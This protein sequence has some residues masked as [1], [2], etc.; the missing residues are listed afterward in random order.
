SDLYCLFEVDSPEA[1]FR[2]K[3]VCYD[4][5]TLVVRL[6][7]KKVIARLPDGTLTMQNL[8]RGI[9]YSLSRM[10]E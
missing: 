4:R 3:T 6:G 10:E 7:R 1:S 5:D 2:K 9:S 8:A